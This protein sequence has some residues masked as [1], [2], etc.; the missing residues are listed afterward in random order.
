[1]NGR[2]KVVGNILLPF[3]SHERPRGNFSLQC[4]CN[5]KQISNEN[6]EK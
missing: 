5:I 1:M 3:N 4:Q 2:N 6:K